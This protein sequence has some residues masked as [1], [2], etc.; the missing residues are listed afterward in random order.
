MKI[1]RDEFIEVLIKIRP[2]L[3]RKNIIEQSTH[4]V[5]TGKT[6]VTYNDQIS[7]SYP[8]ESDFICSVDA[9][10]FY[11]ILFGISSKEIELSFIENKLEIKGKGTKAALVTMQEGPIYERL[12]TLDIDKGRWQKVPDDF[13]EG[14]FFCMFSASKDLSLQELTCIFVDKTIM[15]SSDDIRISQYKMEKGVRDS[16]LI[17]ASSVSEMKNYNFEEYKVGDS[18]IHFKTK[19]EAIFSVRRIQGEFNYEWESFFEVEGEEVIFPKTLKEAIQS[20]EIL[21]EGDFDIDKEIKVI[22]ENSKIVCRGEGPYGNIEVEE[23]IKD[24]SLTLSF[25]INPIFFKEILE[26]SGNVIIGDGVALF[27]SDKFE[28]VMLLSVGNE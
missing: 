9:D 6:I 4:F 2:G 1:N 17:P 3:S 13:L 19:E 20:T 14:L 7:I 8:F 16:F 10:K 24:S 22:I 15:V 12:E 5:F 27:K 26:K 25:F 28:H 23:E 11:K 18:W 21:A